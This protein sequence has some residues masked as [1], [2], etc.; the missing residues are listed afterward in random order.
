MAN[1]FSGY[2]EL[3]TFDV[4]ECT[5]YIKHIVMN[6][7]CTKK[8]QIPVFHTL[9]VCRQLLESCFENELLKCCIIT[10]Y[11]RICECKDTHSLEE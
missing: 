4:N 2:T 11:S 1:H 7:L 3:F 8:K 5:M 6:G 9:S 10:A